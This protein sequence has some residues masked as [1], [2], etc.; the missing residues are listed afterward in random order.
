MKLIKTTKYSV[1]IKNQIFVFYYQLF[2]NTLVDKKNI[3]K[4]LINNTFLLLSTYQQSH[5][6]NHNS[7]I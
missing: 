4:R 7:Y 5:N 6:N 2:I 3:I 1:L